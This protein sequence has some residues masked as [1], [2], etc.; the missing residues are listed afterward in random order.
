MGFA[1][2]TI[3][4]LEMKCAK[5]GRGVRDG[6]T[7]SFHH[8]YPKIFFGNKDVDEGVCLCKEK[9]HLKIEILIQGAEMLVGNVLMG[10]RYKLSKSD[11]ERIT[12]NF[13]R[14]NHI[15]WVKKSDFRNLV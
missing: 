8:V 2:N 6:I 7:L 15:P 3:P 9:C 10:E 11:Y 1:S 5:C 12:K 4:I 13:L 14:T